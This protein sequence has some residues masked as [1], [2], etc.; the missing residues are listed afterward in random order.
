MGA[1]I[2]REIATMSMGLVHESARHADHLAFVVALPRID[3]ELRFAFRGLRP[4]QREEAMVD[5]RSAAWLA[6]S[7]LVRR[8]RDPLGVGV[9]GI[10]RHS[11]SYVLR[12]RKLGL[13]SVGRQADVLDPRAQR[14]LG[15]RVLSLDHAIESEK[16]P[17]ALS[18][19]D[20]LCDDRQTTPADQ[21][22]FRL[23]FAQWVAGLPPRKRQVVELFAQGDGTGLVAHKL[24]ITPGAISQVRARLAESWAVFQG[25]VDRSR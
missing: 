12:G 14:R 10:A 22:A 5:G 3:R 15:L 1:V 24:S 20:W 25:E 7:G 8:G 13:G 4:D 6:W 2:I 19:R 11:A 17:G 9:T 18:W 16:G 23:D 21:A